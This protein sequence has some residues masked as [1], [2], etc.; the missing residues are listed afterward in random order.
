MSV[1]SLIVSPA[2][3]RDT[4]TRFSIL[5]AVLLALAGCDRETLRPSSPDISRQG[6]ADSVVPEKSLVIT[7]LSVIEANAY[8]TWDPSYGV[9]DYRGAFTFGRLID[10]MLPIG[11]RTPL[12][13]A[14]FVIRWL[15]MWEQPQTINSF[16]IPARPL[17]RPL[18]IDPW[19]AASGCAPTVAD[20]D[21]VLDF[22]QAPF[23]LLAITNRPDLRRPVNGTDFPSG[24]QGRFVFGAIGPA[25][26]K[27]FFTV[28][29][30]YDLPVT[31]LDIPLVDDAAL[32]T[33]L[34]GE[35]WNAL[36]R[37]SFGPVY[38]YALF[39]VTH[40][41]TRRDRTP[42]RRNGS[43]LFQIRT[44]E[45]ALSPVPGG[46]DV[47]PLGLWELREFIIGPS[48]QVVQTT[49]KQE[50]DISFNGSATLGAFV[51]EN[52]SAILAGQYQVPSAYQGAPFLGGAGPTPIVLQWNVPG[53]DEDGR[54]AFAMGTCNGCHLT[55]TGT[56]FLHV[57][58]R[59]AGVRAAISDFLAGQLAGARQADFTALLSEP[60]T[61]YLLGPGLDIGTGSL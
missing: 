61:S 2:L 11:E 49:V 53:I 9:N 57:K 18:I 33:R 40:E 25:G 36:G 13:R 15:R 42:S 23:R 47:G 17:I 29:F 30:E 5:S 16:V 54:H 32:E 26:E 55:E 28:I 45:V 7:D 24:G 6:L 34:W 56:T 14:R 4:M 3:G 44:N 27:L 58:P 20:E 52:L 46:D 31:D 43:A 59:E 19:R 1:R 21:C 12:G 8:T 50:P 48:G 10:N 22:A 39:G 38:N 37:L 41:F 51:S 35:A 60:W